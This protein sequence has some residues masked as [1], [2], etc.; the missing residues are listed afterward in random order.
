[1][2]SE[3]HTSMSNRNGLLI[4]TIIAAI[5]VVFLLLFFF[6]NKQQTD[7]SSISTTNEPLV[8]ESPESINGEIL[9]L[10]IDS[11]TFIIEALVLDEN[12]AYTPTIFE[13]TYTDETE[14]TKRNIAIPSS[15]RATSEM[16]AYELQV[17]QEI[18]VTTENNPRMVQDLT[19]T[20][21]QF[22]Y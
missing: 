17:G 4:I 9:S 19:A 15:E 20:S 8:L 11:G 21:L 1:M 10:D 6:Y 2:S 7:Q 13:I 3:D 12:N 14:M 22:F 18:I 5:I 16:T